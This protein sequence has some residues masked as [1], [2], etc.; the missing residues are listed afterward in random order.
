MVNV[1]VAEQGE[2]YAAAT[3]RAAKG[4][5]KRWATVETDEDGK[6]RPRG[7]APDRARRGRALLGL[8]LTVS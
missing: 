6:R 5:S 2:F 1:M 7:K 3:A 4:E 8:R